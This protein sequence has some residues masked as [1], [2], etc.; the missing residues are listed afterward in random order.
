MLYSILSS[1]GSMSEKLLLLL[2]S[3]LALLP[4]LTVHEWAHGYTAY[5]L[6]DSTAKADGRLSLNPLD[7]LDPFGTLML[8]LVGFGWAKPVPVNTRYFK[9]PRR[10]FALTSLAGPVSNILLGFVSTLLYVFAIYACSAWS[11]S[12]MTAMVIINVFYFSALY[13]LGLG[14]FNLI[15]LPPLDGSNILTCLLPQ[16]IAMHYSKIRY[17]S[18]YIFIALVVLRR[19]PMLEFIPEIVFWPVTA[20]RSL[21]FELFCKLGDLIFSMFFA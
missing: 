12:E 7:H 5:K 13:N 11:V 4:A 9:K 14:L 16:R 3:V 2:I 20:G 17:Y 21:L 15:P 18:S 1:G 10:D 8:L 6:G 19:I